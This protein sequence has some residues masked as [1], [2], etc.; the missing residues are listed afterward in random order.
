MNGIAQGRIQNE[1]KNCKDR[2]WRVDVK[3][4]KKNDIIKSEESEIFKEG[5][6][7]WYTAEV[8]QEADKG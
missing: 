3:R 7:Q 5:Y 2:P 6:S 1:K 4:E 8:R